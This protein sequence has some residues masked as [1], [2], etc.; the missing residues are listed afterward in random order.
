MNSSTNSTPGMAFVGPAEVNLYAAIVLRSAI[1][2]Y[3]K[4]GMKVNASYTPTNM[5][6]SATGHTGKTYKRGQLALAQADLDSTI[7]EHKRA[8]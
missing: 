1:K 8:V 6:R 7:E 4:T 3:L 5:L 2:L